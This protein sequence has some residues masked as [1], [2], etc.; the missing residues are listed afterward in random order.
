MM[1]LRLYGLF[2][3]ELEGFWKWSC[4][5]LRYFSEISP[6]QQEENCKICLHSL[7]S[8]RD[9]NAGHQEYEA[10]ELNTKLQSVQTPCLFTDM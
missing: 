4:S 9:L 5:I 10:G 8:N 1:R 3:N 7:F 6:I 2:V